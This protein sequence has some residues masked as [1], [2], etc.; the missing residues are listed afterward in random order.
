[1]SQEICKKCH[2]FHAESIECPKP[3]QVEPSPKIQETNWTEI[4]EEAK[5]ETTQ[6]LLKANLELT[7]MLEIV[8]DVL[9]ERD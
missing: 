6:E 5:K 4:R 3:K 7:K 9:G 8:N 1:M 2:S